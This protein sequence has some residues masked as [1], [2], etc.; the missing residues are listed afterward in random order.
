[1][2]LSNIVRSGIFFLTGVV[3]LSSCGEDRDYVKPTLSEIT[4]S[5]YSSV[6]IQPD[7]LYEVYA[8]AMGILDE[9]YLEEGDL[10]HKGQ[11]LMKI[12]SDK[13]E[14][15]EKNAQLN[16]ELAR[17]NVNGKAALLKDLQDQID[18]AEQKFKNDSSNFERQKRVRE[19]GIGSEVEYEARR[20]SYIS[21]KNNLDILH[22]QFQRTKRELETA[23]QQAEN[24]YKTNVSNVNDHLVKSEINGKLYDILLEPGEMV[25]G[26]LPVAIIG[27]EER[28]IIEMLVDEVD[29]VK[30]A[31]GQKVIVS[32]DAYHNKS[33]EAEVTKIY[34]NKNLRTQTFKI[35]G[36]FR[37][38]PKVLYPG[39]AGE[40]NIIIET[41]ENTMTL[42]LEYIGDGNKVET[43]DGQISVETG[44]SNMTHIE[45]ISGIDTNTSV[46][47]PGK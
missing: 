28:F 40:A 19:K 42:P 22:Q 20:L 18:I 43:D 26:Q 2:G 9:V 45:I 25:N 30:L 12:Q 21:S 32:L 4:E 14:L 24:N 10:V 33:F 37:N 46:Y 23:L 35:E 39:L 27:D 17:Q 36:T 16:L 29:I 5:V 3:L 11:T 38:A 34:P 44:L 47:L 6:T 41:H 15:L 31:L 1:M 8:G 13:V 7:S